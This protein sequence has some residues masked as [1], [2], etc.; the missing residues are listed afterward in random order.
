MSAGRPWRNALALF[1]CAAAAGCAGDGS[2]G[3]S[4]G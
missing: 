4:D 3:G 2:G 1:A